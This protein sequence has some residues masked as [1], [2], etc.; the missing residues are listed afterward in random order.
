VAEIKRQLSA[1]GQAIKCVEYITEQDYKGS[2][3]EKEDVLKLP[4]DIDE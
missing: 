2:F 4:G 3:T 1:S